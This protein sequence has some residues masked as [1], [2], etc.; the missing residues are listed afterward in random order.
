MEVNQ[1]LVDSDK[2]VMT[3]ISF[4]CGELK[5]PELPALFTKDYPGLKFTT[6]KDSSGLEGYIADKIAKT[7]QL[8][9][10]SSINQVTK[11]A[12]IS[13]ALSK[14]PKIHI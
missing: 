2:T 6:L 11:T 14:I 12:T 10:V 8:D 7:I 4:P 9:V 5:T 1:H 3:E 13:I